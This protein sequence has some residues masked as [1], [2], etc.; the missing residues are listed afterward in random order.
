MV[1]RW[2]RYRV[3]GCD[4]LPFWEKFQA[5]MVIEGIGWIQVR[6]ENYNFGQNIWNKINKSSETGQDKKILI[7]TFAC[8]LTA[9]AKV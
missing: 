1:A 8:F 2:V 6:S 5:L 3:I 7:P 4:C 9:V